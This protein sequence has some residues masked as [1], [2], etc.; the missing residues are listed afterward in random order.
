MSGSPG[1][2]LDGADLVMDPALTE[3]ERYGTVRL[4][5]RDAPSS[6]GAHRPGSPASGIEAIRVTAWHLGATPEPVDATEPARSDTIVWV[7]VDITRV[8]AADDLH[9]ALL[10]FCGTSLTLP[11]VE[12]LLDADPLP[13]ATDLGDGI[14]NVTSFSVAPRES[15]QD[16]SD[17]KASKAGSLDFQLVEFL[18]AERWI[19]SCWHKRRPTE[20]GAHEAPEHDPEDHS[21]LVDHVTQRWMQSPDLQT[22]GDLGLRVLYEL[23]QSYTDARRV[24]WAWHESWELHFYVQRHLTERETL[25]QLRGQIKVFRERLEALNRPGMSKNASLI[26]FDHVTDRAEAE[27][28]DDA[29]DR[30]L[31]NLHALND[32]L[33]SSTDLFATETFAHQSRQAERFQELAGIVAAVLLVPTLVVGFFGANTRLPGE[34]AWSGFAYMAVAMVLSALVTYVLLRWWRGRQD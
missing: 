16:P 34:K 24:L 27:L 25:R 19:V 28:V 31:A 15:E 2:L 4:S 3:V 33:R 6:R 26:W 1:A 17:R 8:E 23:A 22:A 13:K 18:A 20:D 29:V 14:R 21:A 7:D 9:A 11:M 12:Q 10:P 32:V 5:L 30:A